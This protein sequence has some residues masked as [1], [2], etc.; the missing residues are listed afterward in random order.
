MYIDCGTEL[1]FCEEGIIKVGDRKN[2]DHDRL[3]RRGV[4]PFYAELP[5]SLL[6]F[7]VVLA[8]S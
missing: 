7:C 4:L 3:V 1:L 2:S 8:S 6:T 5:K